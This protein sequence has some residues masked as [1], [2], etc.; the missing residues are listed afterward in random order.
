[1]KTF[2]FLLPNNFRID[3]KASYPRAG[4]NKLIKQGHK[5]DKLYLPYDRNGIAS[6][7]A[8][9]TLQNTKTGY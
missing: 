3:V 2:A 8:W 6:I 4:Y 9:V 7:Y 1:M 5:I